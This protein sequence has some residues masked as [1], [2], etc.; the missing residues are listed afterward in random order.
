MFK[1]RLLFSFLSFGKPILR[2]M[3]LEGSISLLANASNRVAKAYQT[4]T[5][6]STYWHWDISLPGTSQ[7]SSFP[8]YVR[9]R[10]ASLYKFLQLSWSPHSNPHMMVSHHQPYCGTLHLPALMCNTWH[11]GYVFNEYTCSLVPRPFPPP[12]F[13]HL[14]YANTEGEGLGDLIM[15]DYV[16]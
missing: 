16:R 14:Q 10:C 6:Q 3:G 12:V 4:Q 13:D 9:Y 15:C 11:M 7:G 1:S 2:W 5:K 8:S